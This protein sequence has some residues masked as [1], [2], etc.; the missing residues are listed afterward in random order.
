VIYTTFP[1]IFTFLIGHVATA[2]LPLPKVKLSR[3]IHITNFGNHFK[4]ASKYRESKNRQE[5]RVADIAWQRHLCY[6]CENQII[7]I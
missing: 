7:L 2:T 5:G 4:T 1:A 6:L 3:K